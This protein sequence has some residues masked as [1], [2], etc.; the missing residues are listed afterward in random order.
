MGR[1]SDLVQV[2]RL[3]ALLDGV[4]TVGVA[5][6]AESLDESDLILPPDDASIEQLRELLGDNRLI[7]G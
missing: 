6:D 3:L 1:P 7:P 5:H 2:R 4:R